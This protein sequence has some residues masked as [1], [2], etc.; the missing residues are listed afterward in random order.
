MIIM[1]GISRQPII[2]PL[3]TQPS[4]R[5]S[6]TTVNFLA[7]LWHWPQ[8]ASG[9]TESP[10]DSSEVQSLKTSA[11]GIQLQKADCFCGSL[12]AHSASDLRIPSFDVLILSIRVFWELRSYL[13]TIKLCISVL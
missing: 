12:L 4:G 13:L 6:A 3:V 7:P 10:G 1:A 2:R 9:L 5:V 8:G 11:P